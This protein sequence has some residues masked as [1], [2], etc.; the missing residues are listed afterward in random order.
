MDSLGSNHTPL[1]KL[2]RNMCHAAYTRGAKSAQEED[3]R[4]RRDER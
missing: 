3:S 1:R 4:E 2:Y